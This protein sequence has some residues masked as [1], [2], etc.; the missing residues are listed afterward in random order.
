MVEF[1]LVGVLL[2]LATI[3]II[4][5]SYLM[6]CYHTLQYAAKVTAKYSS[7]HGADCGISPSSCTVAIKDIARVFQNN[8]IG[9]QPSKVTMTFTTDSGTVT[10]CKLAGTGTLCSSLTSYWPP[11]GDNGVG[12][13]IAIRGDYA[14]S[15]ALAVL[16]PGRSVG[17]MIDLPG[18]SKQ[19]IQF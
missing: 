1:A 18:D 4:S 9:I 3:S 16:I 15:S 12:K 7:V 10:T 17:G 14:I 6:W 19:V 8:A 13:V 2:V 11:A 5:M